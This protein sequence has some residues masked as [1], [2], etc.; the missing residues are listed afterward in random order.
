M[1]LNNGMKYHFYKLKNPLC[2]T[3]YFER[4]SLWPYGKNA[5]LQNHG[6]FSLQLHYL[7]H[8]WIFTFRKGVKP[9]IPLDIKSL[10]SYKDGF[11][12]KWPT[13]VEMPLNKETKQNWNWLPVLFSDRKDRNVQNKNCFSW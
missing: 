3:I 10:L 4:E 12:I 9:L 8:L 11:C 6:E 7:V 1:P 2:P 5:G 13:K